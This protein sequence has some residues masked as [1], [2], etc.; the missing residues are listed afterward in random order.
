MCADAPGDAA[1]VARAASQDRHAYAELVRRHQSRLR[2]ML[3]RLVKGND[4]LADDLAQEAFIQAWRK[5]DQF[6]GDAQFST[7]LYR[8]AYNGFLAHARAAKPEDS[9]DDVDGDA[10]PIAAA[11]RGGSELRI[12][13]ERALQQLN[14]PE[15]A[16][17]LQCYYNDLSHE[18]AAYV[19]SMPL[20][21]L[22]THVLKAK[23][24]LKLAL[25]AWQPEN[26]S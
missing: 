7:W 16:A 8:I 5:L 11:T 4:A 15:R 23:Q 2:G 13:M 14:E 17:V 9:Y 20:G 10:P 26:P 3:R 25:V 1:L 19:L 24:K 6:R 12:D 22:K 21:T 18:E